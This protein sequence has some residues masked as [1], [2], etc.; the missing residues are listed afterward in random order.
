MYKTTLERISTSL[1]L[2]KF[3]IMPNVL[4]ACL[5]GCLIYLSSCNVICT[6]DPRYL[7]T[8]VEGMKCSLLLSGFFGDSIYF[9][10]SLWLVQG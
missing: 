9:C 3:F 8:F 4:Q 10:C 6:M 1:F 5:I 2:R 7:N